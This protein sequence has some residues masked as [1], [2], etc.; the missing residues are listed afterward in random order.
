M[1]PIRASRSALAF[2]LLLESTGLAGR[3]AAEAPPGTTAREHRTVTF[4]P[5]AGHVYEYRVERTYAIARGRPPA[6]SESV[7]EARILLE[8][9]DDGQFR[10]SFAEVAM[11]GEADPAMITTGPVDPPRGPL[12]E[13]EKKELSE[14]FR[15]NRNAEGRLVLVDDLDVCPRVEGLEHTLSTSYQGLAWALVKVRFHGVPLEDDTIYRADGTRTKCLSP[16]PKSPGEQ[17]RPGQP[18]TTH[19]ARGGLRFEGIRRA[20]DE[21]L[22]QFA[23]IE[24]Y[25][26]RCDG[27]VRDFDEPT[28]RAA[29]RAR[30][31]ML[32]S[33]DMEVAR[34]RASAAWL[35]QSTLKITLVSVTP[36][37]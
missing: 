32:A 7:F 3:L 16:L 4:R 18:L 21:E 36:S 34:G 26:V 13:E 8:A 10:W 29:Y 23:I 5:L 35:P 28:G 30:D 15:V 12:S 31:G 20:G 17:A 9:G 24:R 2:I 37:R 33:Y 22:A 14:P 1:I 19:Q 25:Q 11:R 6:T 27:Q